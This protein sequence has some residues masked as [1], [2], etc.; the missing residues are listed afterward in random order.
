MANS[1]KS[2]LIFWRWVF[3]FGTAVAYGMLMASH[4]FDLG[5]KVMIKFIQNL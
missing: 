5:I 4:K 1:E 2:S 3:V